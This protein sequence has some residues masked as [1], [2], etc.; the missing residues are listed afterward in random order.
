MEPQS[1]ASTSPR[2]RLR[3]T[4]F[5]LIASII[6]A[7]A[8]SLVGSDSLG[9]GE[10]SGGGGPG[11]DN[12]PLPGGVETDEQFPAD[13]V[14]AYTGPDVST[15]ANTFVDYRQ[16]RARI[17][18]VFADDA[19]GGNTDSYIASKIAL[20]GGADF[21]TRY[22]EARVASTDFL[23]AVDGIAKDACERAATNKTGPFSG[24]DP[25]AVAGAD[26]EVLAAQLYQKMV[27]RKASAD[28]TA[29]AKKLAADLIPL[30]PSK[31]SAWAGVCE[32]LVRHPDSLFTLPPSYA[33]APADDKE[34]MRIVKFANDFAS[35][36]P[37]EAEFASLAG[38]KSAEMV[39]YFFALPE[40]RETMMHRLR[41]RTES[42]GTPETDEPARLWTYLVMNRAPFQDL[43]R[44]EYSVD[45]NF[46]R[47]ERPANHGKTGVLTMK[48]FIQ[49]KLNLPHYNYSARVMTDFFGQ[50]FEV[51]QAILD[52]R[53][54]ATVSSTVQ[55]GTTCYNCHSIL[56][57]LAHQRLKWADD[58]SYRENDEKGAPIDDSD[59][60]LVAAYRFKGKG[61]AAFSEQG[62]K[63]E[64]FLR[65]TMQTHVNMLFGRPMRFKEDERTLYK[66]L[67]R[68]S[69]RENGNIVALI[70]DV[71]ASPGYIGEAQ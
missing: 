65:T 44:G 18:T 42:S 20:L 45:A 61:M 7:S 13:L 11:E 16:L 43:L 47:V 67:W 23:L 25:A 66:T 35:R 64:A 58:G 50:T 19:I 29:A 21:K 62:V 32:M 28:E 22:T 59:R 17:K 51:T 41:I 48:G 57:P 60:G 33:T 69:F 4:S 49:G 9:D 56:T 38:K 5:M 71:V 70:K 63:K 3:K 39:D 15:Y 27:F 24:R 12:S 37:T 36:P 6:C 40:F 1:T 34:R 26:E 14:A 10:K 2:D 31:T 30:S 55:Q 54:T 68:T 46:N 52:E 53:S 8:C